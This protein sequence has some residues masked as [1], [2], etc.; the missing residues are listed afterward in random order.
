NNLATSYRQAGRTT[1]AITLLEQVA[2]DSERILGPHHPDTLTA[3][4]NLATSYRQA[5]RTTDAI[6]LLEQVAADSERIL[7]PDH[8]NAVTMMKVLQ[9]WVRGRK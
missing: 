7:G 1:D 3:R 5:G 4:N 2:A 6:T 8:P 9:I